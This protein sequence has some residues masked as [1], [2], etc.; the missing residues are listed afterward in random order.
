MQRQK[1]KKM[2]YTALF[3]ALTCA[4]TM[5]LPIPMPL[6]NGYVNIG[7]CFV[8]LGAW[9]LGPWYGA[10]AGGVGSALADLFMNYIPYVP[11]TL[12]IKGIMAIIAAFFF[13]RLCH[14]SLLGKITGGILTELWM[15]LGYFLYGWVFLS[16]AAVSATAIPGNLLQGAVGL[17]A[18]ILLSAALKKVNISY[19]ETK[20]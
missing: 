5:V 8:L 19:K 14:H 10:F 16:S 20:L 13:R 12:I 11:G 7:D 9:V 1:Y 3:T 15:V 17:V 4:A 18:A 6:T 2:I